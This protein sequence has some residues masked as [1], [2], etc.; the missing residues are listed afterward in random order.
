MPASLSTM[1]ILGLLSSMVWIFLVSSLLFC[2]LFSLVT[3]S[4]LVFKTLSWEVSLGLTHLA[5]CIIC[6][7]FSKMSIYYP[8][9]FW[10]MTS[11]DVYSDTRDH[12]LVWTPYLCRWQYMQN[13]HI[14]FFCYF[15][16]MF[17]YSIFFYFCCDLH[18]MSLG[19]KHLFNFEYLPTLDWI[20]MYNIDLSLCR[21]RLLSVYSHIYFIAILHIHKIC[22]TKLFILLPV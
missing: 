3:L 15:A 22:R 18:Y 12:G 20:N 9:K 14:I 17:I 21:W 1:C 11:S 8:A 2:R 6:L 10:L 4:T 19:P 7:K 13:F 16:G 5:I